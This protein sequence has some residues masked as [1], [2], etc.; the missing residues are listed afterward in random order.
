MGVK[1]KAVLWN[2]QKK[3]IDRTMLILIG[4]YLIVFASAQMALHPQITPETLIIRA[5]GTLAILMLHVVLAI[6]PL[7][8]INVRFLPLLYNRRHF[9]VTLAIFALI[10]GGFSLFQFHGLSDL[11]PLVSLFTS[12]PNYASFVDFPFQTFG[13]FALLIL[14]LMAATSHDFWLHNLS[15][16]V[17]KSLHMLVYLAYTLL[18]FHV[19]LG[20]VQLEKSPLIIDLLAMGAL[21]LCGLHLW[22]AF[23]ER[24]RREQQSPK[25][26][27]EGFYEVGA[28]SDIPENRAKMIIIGNENI[29][30][31]KYDGQLSAV[32][33]V[34]KHQNGP[35]G[36]GKIVNGCITCPW[37]A[38]EYLP[39]NGCAPA[40]FTEKLSTYEL[41]LIDGVVYVHP[42]PKAEGTYIE[43][44]KYIVN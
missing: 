8:R 13:F 34:C 17:W 42:E 19:L 7:C 37:H 6:G 27:L 31:F 18:I 41:K 32:S 4:L 5:S 16:K 28:V 12:N 3:L 2:R 10:H 24:K 1:Y 11:N 35:L 40:P 21:S 33:N 36:E 15:P 29:A 25:K 38:Y 30:V 39:A 23:L 9:G 26:E 43:P 44:I 14:F 20:V 22:S